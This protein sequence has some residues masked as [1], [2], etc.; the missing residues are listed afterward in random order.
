MC[1]CTCMQSM[2]VGFGSGEELTSI[3]LS[4]KICEHMCASLLSSGASR[5]SSQELISARAR[6][7]GDT[8]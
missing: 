6:G 1:M 3:K 8:G 4:L 5:T 7:V 2:T